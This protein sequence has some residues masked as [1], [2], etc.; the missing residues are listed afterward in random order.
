MT[1]HGQELTRNVRLRYT[2]RTNGLANI[3]GARNGQFGMRRPAWPNSAR[4]VISMLISEYGFLLR[5]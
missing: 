3:A 4:S 1:F 2:M 5:S